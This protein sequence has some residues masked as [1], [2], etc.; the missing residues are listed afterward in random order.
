MPLYGTIDLSGNQISGTIP[1]ALFWA[2]DLSPF[3]SLLVDLSNNKLEGSLPTALFNYTTAPLLT[4]FQAKFSGNSGL[5]G[6]IPSTFLSSFNPAPST[7]TSTV[8]SG[9]SMSAFIYLDGT[10]ITGTLSIPDFSERV[11]LAPLQLTF[12]AYGSRLQALD[13]HHNASLALH[14]LDVSSSTQLT[15]TLPNSLF[16]SSSIL[17]SLYASNTA[18]SGSMPNLGTLGA[19]KLK[20]LDLSATN[21]DFCAGTRV[22]WNPVSINTCLLTSTSAYSCPLVYPRSCSITAPPALGVPLTSGPPPCSN[23]TRP[24]PSFICIDGHWSLKDLFNETTLVLPSDAGEVFVGNMTSTE[25]TFQGLGTTLII[26]GCA[27]NLEAASLTVSRREQERIGR[28]LTQTLIAT[29]PESRCTN[30]SGVALRIELADA[31]C[32]RTTTSQPA[33]MGRISVVISVQSSRCRT[34]WIILVSV[35]SSVAVILLVI[36]AAT[37]LCFKR[38]PRS[39]QSYAKHKTPDRSSAD[40]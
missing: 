23:V 32:K 6:S 18:L 13:I 28:P 4:F 21:I 24:S 31:G 38:G 12:Y 15:G 39:D 3:I 25:V 10:G 30:T 19:L 7:S 5:G 36:F 33:E 16:A 20:N 2:V 27:P 17:S 14:Y 37:V 1:D 29:G 9:S 22:A 11:A 34:W 26:T 40:I 8:A 35:L